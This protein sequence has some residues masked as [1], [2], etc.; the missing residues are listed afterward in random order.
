MTSNNNESVENISIVSGK[1]L[2]PLSNDVENSTTSYLL[3]IEKNSQNL[4]K[5]ELSTKE[6]DMREEVVADLEKAQ[7]YTVT[8]LYYF[9]KV[10]Y[11]LIKIKENLKSKKGRFK[12]FIDS[13][14]MNERTAQRYMKIAGDKRF[15]A[16]TENELKQLYHL[17]Q[18]KMLLMTT[19]TDEEFNK[20]IHDEDYIFPS[21]TQK[22]ST[23]P[24]G[25]VIEQDMY[26]K[27]MKADKAFVIN[28]YNSLL[29]KY[30]ELEKGG[31]S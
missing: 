29:K 11:R 22:S 30:L 5:F 25:F 2:P 20:A 1:G 17:T 10:G 14:G 8:S 6:K 21:K 3:P 16:M 13:I 4:D 31:E 9:I 26:D 15:K 19:F 7:L 24:S 12:K 18:G 28:E 23:M 27:L